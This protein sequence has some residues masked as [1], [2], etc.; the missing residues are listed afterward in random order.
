[1]PNEPLD[2]RWLEAGWRRKL[3]K[4]EA[5]ELEAWLAAHPE[6]RDSWRT[7]TQLT[8]LLNR[9]PEA[10][11][12]SNFTARVLQAVEREQASAERRHSPRWWNRWLPRVAF[13]GA[14]VVL[15]VAV[16]SHQSIRQARTADIGKSVVA[17]SSVPSLPSVEILQDF[18]AV[19]ALPTT[20]PADEALLSLLQ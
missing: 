10:P 16:F 6:S 8:S 2:N 15:G 7:E 18:D 14:F 11:V 19:R 3:S 1:M 13:A 9:L 4:A 17:V 20:P 12:S 5:A